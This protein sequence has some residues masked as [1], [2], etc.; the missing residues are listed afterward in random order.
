LNGE[1]MPF[2]G[3]TLNIRKTERLIDLRNTLGTAL[4]LRHPLTW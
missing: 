2:D 3:P 1:R 4:M